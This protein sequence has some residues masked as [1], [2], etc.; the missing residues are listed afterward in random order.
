MNHFKHLILAASLLCGATT[1]TAQVIGDVNNDSQVNATD[2]AIVV[3][4]IAGLDVDAGYDCDINRDKQVNATDIA[5]VVNVIAGL[6]PVIV[7]PRA[8]VG[9]DISLLPSYEKN[10]AT[11]RDTNGARIT[12]MLAYFKQQG[13]TAM[14]VRLFVDPT[15]ASTTEKGEGVVQD[16][17]YVTQLGAR[18]KAAGFKF[19]LDFHYSD[20]WADPVKQYTPASWATL[21]DD[22]LIVKIGDYT[23]ECLQTLNAAGATPDYIQ[24]GNEISYGMLWGP[25]GTSTSNL[26]K[27]YVNND[28][29]WQR[30]KDLLRSAITACREECPKAKIVI[31]SERTTQPSTLRNYYLRLAELDYDII[32]L[33]YYPHFH[34]TLA[35]LENSISSLES[36]SATSKK[37]IMIVETG[38][39]HTYP[40]EDTVLEFEGTEDGQQLFTQ[41][42]VGMLRNHENVTGLFWWWPEANECGLNWSTKRV[43]D[44]WYNAGLWDNSTG[45]AMKAIG[46]LS[47][48]TE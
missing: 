19:M 12:D 23:R 18:I 6:E 3:N 1:A 7:E 11:Y 39:Y 10:G 36:Y 42:L 30:F 41:S 46:D 35:T 4:K 5:Q 13:F 22:E 31:H 45:R 15:Q 21:S 8:V 47:A 43:T 2:I 17:A 32:G 25:V 9:G 34:S 14:R 24:T 26:K 38:Q 37:E 27:V 20:S 48:F 33:S 29:N 16:L 44:N 28:A 40:P